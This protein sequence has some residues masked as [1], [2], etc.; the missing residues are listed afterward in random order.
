MLKQGHILSNG[1]YVTVQVPK[2]IFKALRN[3]KEASWFTC[4]IVD[5]DK[6]LMFFFLYGVDGKQKEKLKDFLNVPDS[7][8]LDEYDWII[9]VP[10]T[11]DE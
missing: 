8:E 10:N 3:L 4:E 9:V 6:A 2:P 11:A 5:L 1:R 7:K